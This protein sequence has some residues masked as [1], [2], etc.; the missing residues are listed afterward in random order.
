MEQ[1]PVESKES[2][3]TRLKKEIQALE[4]KLREK[5]SAFSIA[6]TNLDGARG[7]LVDKQKELKNLERSESK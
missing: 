6:Q 5:E 7:R 3:I 2:K 1:N 4:D